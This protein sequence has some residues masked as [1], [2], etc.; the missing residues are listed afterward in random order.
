MCPTTPFNNCTGMRE[1]SPG[2]GRCTANE[3]N[4]GLCKFSLFDQICNPFFLCRPNFPKH[5]N[6]F[7]LFILL[8]H[9]NDIW[10][11]S[12]YDSITA[13]MDDGTLSYPCSSQL[14]RDGRCN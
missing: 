5:D 3:C 4:Q 9:L 1:P 8:K 2:F 13:D 6:G 12:P 11:G 7:C 10:M 14:I